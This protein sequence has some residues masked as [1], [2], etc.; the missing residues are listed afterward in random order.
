VA[1]LVAA[2]CARPRSFAISFV[3]NPPC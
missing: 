1:V 2:S 3:P